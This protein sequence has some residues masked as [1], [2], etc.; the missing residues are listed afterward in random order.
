MK[1]N[2]KRNASGNIDWNAS[3]FTP[4]DYIAHWDEFGHALGFRYA[5]VVEFDAA[6]NDHDGIIRDS[7]IRAFLTRPE[8]Y[9][10]GEGKQR[11]HANATQNAVARA[12]TGKGIA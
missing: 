6:E 10:T 1:T 11:I 8:G 4:K 3:T 7:A 5:V 12:A 9:L 2:I